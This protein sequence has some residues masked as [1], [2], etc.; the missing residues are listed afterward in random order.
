MKSSIVRYIEMTLSDTAFESEPDI[1]NTHGVIMS[2]TSSLF[3]LV[4]Y[5]SIFN[6]I[7]MTM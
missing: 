1:M 6:D 4:L 7:S 2:F 3:H 5:T